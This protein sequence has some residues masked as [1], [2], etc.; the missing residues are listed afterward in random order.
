MTFFAWLF[1]FTYLGTDIRRMD[2]LYKRYE[3]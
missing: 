2:E 3:G 1:E